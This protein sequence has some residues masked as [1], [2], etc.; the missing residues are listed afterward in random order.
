MTKKEINM[1]IYI[2]IISV[3]ILVIGLNV[4]WVGFHNLDLCHNEMTIQ[5]E[6]NTKFDSLNVGRLIIKEMRVYD[7]EVWSLGDCYLAGLKGIIQGLYISLAG[8][9]LLGLSYNIHLRPRK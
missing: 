6:I 2:G 3:I 7:K 1:N 9:F 5:S 4:F 8:M